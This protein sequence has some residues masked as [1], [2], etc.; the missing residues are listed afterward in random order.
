MQAKIEAVR[1][2]VAQC[3]ALAEAKFG[4]KMPQV[5]IRF[6]LTGRAAGMAGYQQSWG[7][8]AHS[9]YLRF[10]TVHMR[11]GGQ[12]WEHLLNDTVP[13]EVAHTVCQAFPKYG[14]QHDA[15]WKSVCRALGGN[16]NRC[17]SA[18]DAPEA[19]A[20]QRPFTYT[21]TSGAAVAVS[22]IIHRKIQNGASYRYRALGTVNKSC[23]FTLTTAHSITQPKPVA[24][25]V[26]APVVAPTVRTVSAVPGASNADKVRYLI[27]VAKRNAMSADSVVNAAVLDLGMTR[28]LA[29]T[30]VKN[31][32]SKA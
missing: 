7:S 23:A 9:F 25:T 14:R 13:H 17:Y 30:Y 21:S 18:A 12:S 26:R 22:P 4:I 27:A 24:P 29:K 32:W 1:N 15:G 10:N 16:G 8:G 11:L 19:V 2:K 28:A 3:I 5:N 6:D 31:N 20:K